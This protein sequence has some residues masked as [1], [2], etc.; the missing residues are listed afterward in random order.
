MALSTISA[1]STVKLNDINGII[2]AVNAIEPASNPVRNCD[3]FC[4]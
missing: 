3:C 4:R 1:G 2:N